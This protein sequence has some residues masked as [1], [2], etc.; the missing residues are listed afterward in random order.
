MS[1]KAD[2]GRISALMML[3]GGVDPRDVARLLGVRPEQVRAWMAQPYQSS[4][5]E[6]DE[7][8]S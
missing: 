7:Q 1:D 4:E 2:D 3:A 6:D 8:C 5:S